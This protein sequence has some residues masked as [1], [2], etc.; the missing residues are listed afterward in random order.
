MKRIDFTALNLFHLLK[1]E[2]SPALPMHI[3]NAYIDIEGMIVLLCG[4]TAVRINT[5]KNNPFMFISQSNARKKKHQFNDSLSMLKG[6]VIESGDMLGMDRML[7][8]MLDEGRIFINLIPGQFNFIIISR[9][10][11]VSA[12]YSYRKDA[13]GNL[14]MKKGYRFVEPEYAEEMHYA[15]ITEKYL[16]TS[17]SRDELKKENV[18]N[19]YM[20]NGKYHILPHILEGEEPVMTS[21]R[22]SDLII[23]AAETETEHTKDKEKDFII[24][25]L[26]KKL[27]AAEK[28][29]R[30]VNK[31]ESI[32][33]EIE[34]LSEKAETLQANAD[35]DIACGEIKLASIRDQGKTLT[36]ELRKGKS[37]Y[38]N[39]E[40]YFDRIKLLKRKLKSDSARKAGI[41]KEIK[42]IQELIEK[43]ES[44]EM[45]IKQKSKHDEHPKKGRI[46]VSPGGFTVIAG[47]NAIENDDITRNVASKGDMF[48][49]A[50]EKKG[51]HVILK[52][53]G[54]Q[55]Q[56][57]DILFAAS[58]AAYYSAGKHS[59]LVEVQYT[60]IRYV[61]KRKKSKPGEIVM[62]R[63]NVVFVKPGIPA[64]Q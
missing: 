8:L 20:I 52:T 41:E 37:L 2:I 28:K 36:I 57:Q 6:A 16:Q 39:V 15:K 4:A 30:N 63:E 13:E 12:L 49:H 40:L 29:L 31:G 44:G 14:I 18:Q 25:G 62:T 7:Y 53:G 34:E 59:G 43:A 51:S 45:G 3:D 5:E 11:A 10:E 32:E 24:S 38:E 35:A 19:L 27:S 22:I 9:D 55:A 21:G 33:K 61:S 47:R 58:I 23:N 54:K 17:N 42:E 26:E 56:K 46:Y 50:R 60:D 1:F 48:F 64:S